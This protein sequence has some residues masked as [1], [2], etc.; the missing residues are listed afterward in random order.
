[1]LQALGEAAQAVLP[2]GTTIDVKES[3]TGDA[4]LVFDKQIERAN[5]EL[6][7]A[8]LG[9]TMLTD[10][11]SSRSQSEVHERN[12]DDKLSEDDRRIITF[13]TNDQLIPMLSLWGHD[14]NPD[15]DEFMFDPG[16]EMDLKEFWDIIVQALGMY[17]IPDDWVSK[18]FGFPITGR[19]VLQQTIPTAVSGNKG[20]SANFQ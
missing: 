18:K 2:E 5:T 12:L 3:S 11:G 19:K 16:D 13:T 10:N 6:S 17:E 14:I 9:G 20:F 4:Y 8:V 15:T 7:K 1:M